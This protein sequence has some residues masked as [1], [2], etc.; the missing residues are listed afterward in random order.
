[1]LFYQLGF[2]LFLAIVLG[3]LAT[4]RNN[5]HRRVVLLIAN[6]CFYSYF[7]YKFLLLIIIS[8]LTDYSIGRLLSSAENN[9]RRRLLLLISLSVDL[10]ILGFFKYYNFFISS[11]AELFSINAKGHLLNLVLPIGISFYTFQTINYVI[12]VFNRKIEACDNVIDYAIFVGFFPSI[13]SGPIVRASSFLPQLKAS[14]K[15]DIADIA[16]GSRLLVTGMFQKIFLADRLGMFVDVVF[17]SPGVFNS[18]TVW[19][20]VVSYSL[21]LYLDFAGY[22]NM[23][24][25]VAR[26]LGYDIGINFNFP[27][28]SKSI[29][30]FWKRWHISLSYWIRDYLYIPLGGSRKGEIR[31]YLN[32]VIAMLLCGL[33]HGASWTFILWGGYH[34]IGLAIQKLWSRS[35]VKLPAL[36]GWA[37]TMLMVVIG[38]IFFRSCDLTHAFTIL[39]QMFWGKPGVSWTFPFAVFAIAATLIAHLLKLIAGW[40]VIT[41]PL[42]SWYLPTLLL[43]ML[44]LVIIFHPGGFRPF[45]YA[46]F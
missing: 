13:L 40:D 6:Y 15:L 28:L 2:L 38:W 46:N 9:S 29:G 10:F 39:R 27:Y 43:S 5:E 19:L 17:K 41:V 4:I 33:W 42:Q 25:G 14:K 31:T 8:T 35:R 11:F 20:A 30:E 16:E 23:A 45:A 34:G 18:S 24:I 21:Q 44:W 7:D 12:D 3:L 1:M 36:V 32:L 22:S 37:L 26:M